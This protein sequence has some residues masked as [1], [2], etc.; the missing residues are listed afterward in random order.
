MAI[1]VHLLTNFNIIIRL[2]LCFLSVWKSS[3]SLIYFTQQKQERGSI[4]FASKKR[5]D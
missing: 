2:F 1:Q 3:E 5:N 4:S